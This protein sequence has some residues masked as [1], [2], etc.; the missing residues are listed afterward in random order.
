MKLK[1]KITK[2]L[3]LVGILSILLTAISAS[4]GFWYVFSN[5][6]RSDLQ[7]YGEIVSAACE[8]GVDPSALSRYESD[9]L[10]VTL[11]N[12]EGNVLFESS[13]DTQ[14]SRMEN[15]GGRPEIVDAKDKGT[16]ES[17]RTS[18]TL[19]K[20]TYYY[21]VQL[22]NGDIVRVAKET[23]S[24]FSVFKGIIPLLIFIIIYVFVICFVFSAEATKNIIRPIEGMALDI[25]NIAYDELIPFA[26]TIEEQR[27]KI[28]RQL[29]RIQLEK[30]KINALIANMAEGFVLFDMEKNVL[31]KN[32][33]AISLLN[34]NDA[35]NV[36]IIQFCRNEK[37]IRCIEQAVE[38]KNCIDDLKIGGREV[39]VLANPV[40]SNH[41]QNGVI[42]VIM[43]VTEKKKSD[44]MRREFT[45]NVSHE[46]KT[47]LTSISGYAEMIENGMAKPEDV[48]DFAHKIHR[49]AGRLVTLIGDILKL[50]RLEEPAVNNPVGQVDLLEIANECV[51]SL[52]MSA[53]QHQVTLHTDGEKAKVMGNRD[54]LYELIYN[55]CDNAIR[56]NRK[57]GS[58]RISV[59]TLQ[60]KVLLSVTD[61]GI[62]IPQ[63]HQERVFER[64]YRVDKSR[65]KETGGTGLGLA[66]VKY[67]A[68]QHHAQIHLES[69]ENQG[70]EI[71]VYFPAV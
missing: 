54:L 3:L 21:A 28:H 2:K 22:D 17:A 11:I 41:T 59:K 37:F 50:S 32:D 61:T 13:K 23:D 43:D 30:D 18:D 31:M 42:C 71:L 6:V 35:T 49:E 45:A 19:G 55:L 44:N 24:I 34:A 38:G 1:S 62:G 40:L 48:K 9:G 69:I 10:R 64:F 8:D 27:A 70:T 36:N 7:T 25:D 29:Q 16:G 14:A 66:I 60:D 47:P 12:Q 68:E 53:V 26:K 15:H 46:L 63:E 5:Q 57:D 52:T 4:F 65:S 39:Q 51:E 33:S 58:V 20:I 67:I 56:Y